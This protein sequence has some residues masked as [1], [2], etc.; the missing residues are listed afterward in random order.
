[1]VDVAS[2]IAGLVTT[3]MSSLD[4]FQS[5]ALW[6]LI[7]GAIFAFCLGFSLGANDVSNAFGTSVGSKVLKIRQAYSLATVVEAAGAILIGYN[8]VDTMRKGVVDVNIYE[9]EEYTFLVGQ[10]GVLAGCATW[11]MIATGLDL[12]VSSSHSI[13]GSTLGFSLVLKGTRGID[14]SVVYRIMASWV[15]SPVLSACI[16]GVMYI[17]LDITVLR[18]KDALKNGLI[19]LPFFYFFCIAFNTF[20]VVF[21]GSK[22]LGLESVDLVWA[23]IISAIAGGLAALFCQFVLRPMLLNYINK[24]DK[25]QSKATVVPIDNDI[26]KPTPIDTSDATLPVN[27]VPEEQ[28]FSFSPK[29]FVKWLLPAKHREEDPHALRLFSTIQVFTACFAG[30]AHGANDVANAIAPLAAM[31]SV[32]QE[33]TVKQENPA[34]I[35][36][37]VFGVTAIVIGLWVLGHRII[38]VV[39]TKMSHVHPASGFTIEF[40]AAVTSILA[41]KLGLPIST[42]H[43]LIG[44]VVAVGTIKSGKGV[45][46]RVFGS[47]ALS[48][49]LT[50]PVTIGI[51]AL[52]TY[53]LTLVA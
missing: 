10:L 51:S 14:W 2:T 23:L 6:I 17:L 43:S 20:N 39:G 22:I 45:N 52:I 34:S 29:G 38:K 24:D 53:L 15:I 36:V 25:P 12:P 32:Y 19:L 46:W 42:T 7:V 5:H 1:M 40:G 30:F 33:G 47:I 4:T 41:S 21:Q 3:T 8:V 18:R 13:V 26:V 48:W 27:A 50:L 16:S 31:L 35:W 9:G 44:S 37:F 28:K 11:L 49:L